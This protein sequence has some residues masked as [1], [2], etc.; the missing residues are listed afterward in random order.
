MERRAKPATTI[1]EYIAQ[2]PA[3]VQRILK[4][5]RTI[6]RKSAPNAEEKISYGM[7]GYFLNGRLV[8]F[9]A[10]KNA[11]GFYPLPSGIVKFKK[12]LASYRQ[13]KGAVNFPLDEPIP[14]E[15]ISR[16]TKF[17]VKE[18]LKKKPAKR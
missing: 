8:W 7:P 1:D 4:K 12:E 6:I 3:D 18:N 16:I 9:S 2:Y 13:T 14:Y 11:I 5:V 17:R 10:L 15:L